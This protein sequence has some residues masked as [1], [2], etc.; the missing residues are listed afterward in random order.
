[1]NSRQALS[2][3]AATLVVILVIGVAAVG[4]YFSLGI[5]PTTNTVVTTTFSPT[6][7]FDTT[8]LSANSTSGLNLVLE[9]N[10]TTYS[11]GQWIAVNISDYNTLPTTNTLQVERDWPI[12]NLSLGP[13]SRNLPIA[14]G[15]FR[16]D[17]SLSNITQANSSEQVQFYQP[18][19]YACPDIMVIQEYAFQPQSDN[20]SWSSSLNC[21]TN[22]Y[23]SYLTISDTINFNGTWTGGQ[24]PV[25]TGSVLMNL[26]LGTYTVVGG[27]EWG[28]IALLHF[29][30]RS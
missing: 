18:G 6:T 16:G 20:A 12:Q 17:Y 8:T 7:S 23:S 19:V 3:I 24:P 28:N 21:N 15:V 4:A 1:M 13:C 11:P 10:S 14:I 2:S 9:L 30:V 25:G 27:D 22:C 5:S 26:S 29:V